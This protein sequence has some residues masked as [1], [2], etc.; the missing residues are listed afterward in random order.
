MDIEMK[1]RKRQMLESLDYIDDDLISSTLKKIKPDFAAAE[2]EKMTWRTPLKY[3]KRFVALAACLVLL[4]CA[5]PLISYI[6]PSIGRI[7]TGNAGAGSDEYSDYDPYTDSAV[8]DYPV[9][10]PAVEI[11]ADVLTGG[12]LVTYVTDFDSANIKAVA[13]EGLWE[14]FHSKV[15]KGEPAVFRK[16]FYVE[17]NNSRNHLPEGVEPDG[18]PVISLTEVV[19]D[20]EKYYFSHRDMLP[21][22]SHDYSVVKAYTYLRLSLKMNERDKQFY[23]LTNDPDLRWWSPLLSTSSPDYEEIYRPEE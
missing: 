6:L 21:S 17:K 12:W 7:F 16:A 1:L 22:Y 4:S 9:D 15:Q 11:Y 2:P 10:M 23:F 13:G 20:G 8:F 3:W 18:N 19:Y 5:I 14:E